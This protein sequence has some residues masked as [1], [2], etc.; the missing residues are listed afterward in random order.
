MVYRGVRVR[1]GHRFGLFLE[2]RLALARCSRRGW[3][4]DIL[5]VLSFTTS[6]LP[7]RALH[8]NCAPSDFMAAISYP[9]WARLTIAHFQCG[10]RVADIFSVVGADDL[11]LVRPMGAHASRSIYL[12]HLQEVCRFLEIGFSWQR[13]HS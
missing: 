9:I 11:G 4:A 6:A 8:L 2:A 12:F 10:R 1:F 13:R 7:N 5:I 3:K